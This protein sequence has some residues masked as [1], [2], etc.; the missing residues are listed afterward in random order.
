MPFP[1]ILGDWL[2]VM[3]YYAEAFAK[4]DLE[5]Q[6]ANG[7]ESTARLLKRWQ[8]MAQ[9]IEQAEAELREAQ[10]DLSIRRCCHDWQAIA[11]DTGAT[12]KDMYVTAACCALNAA[13]KL[14]R[15]LNS[16]ELNWWRDGQLT[17]DEAVRTADR[18]R[19][20]MFAEASNMRLMPRLRP[21]VKASAE[22][23]ALWVASAD[24]GNL[25][26]VLSEVRDL[27]LLEA[28]GRSAA[29]DGSQSQHVETHLRE[30]VNALDAEYNRRLREG[31][32]VTNRLHGTWTRIRAPLDK[33]LEVETGQGFPAL[34]CWTYVNDVDAA[35]LA[36]PQ[37]E[38]VA[39]RLA[40]Q[41]EHAKLLTAACADHL[42]WYVGLTSLLRASGAILG[43]ELMSWAPDLFGYTIQHP[44][45]VLRY[46]VPPDAMWTRSTLAKLIAPMLKG[47]HPD[48]GVADRL[49]ALGHDQPV[50]VLLV[51]ADYLARVAR[52]DGKPAAYRNSKHRQL[53]ER[54]WEEDIGPH[55]RII[56]L[57]MA[58][59]VLTA[60]ENL[61]L[62]D[63][64][65][66]NSVPSPPA[67]PPAEALEPDTSAQLQTEPTFKYVAEEM[68]PAAPAVQ[69][70]YVRNPRAASLKPIPLDLPA[71]GRVEAFKTFM[72]CQ[73]IGL[74][75][76]KVSSIFAVIEHFLDTPPK[77]RAQTGYDDLN[78]RRW[79]KLKRG[80]QRIY[81][82]LET[83]ERLLFHPYARRDWKPSWTDLS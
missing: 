33:L 40:L 67:D 82:R 42:F 11:S 29:E 30:R 5:F 36:Q 41:P 31:V 57:W 58:I 63:Q 64:P 45:K 10:I 16:P 34:L 28:I 62:A 81:V 80:A 8:R 83:D 71:E 27:E 73:G 22:R 32:A 75:V 47:Y 20:A 77:I 68:Q 79:H 14:C 48:D 46:Q 21:V 50:E 13:Q 9:G 18:F 56:L 69:W 37:S 39:Y 25:L 52:K 3:T 6:G 19:E 1:A 74:I 44:G 70:F 17:D 59:G 72:A 76:R 43:D 23:F 60:G 2:G 61:P 55:C 35:L 78:G 49:R 24:D 54:L 4:A 66:R 51:F 7:R 53:V 38:P 12:W 15:S 65:E 26:A